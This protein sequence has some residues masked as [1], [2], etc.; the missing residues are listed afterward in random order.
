MAR[1]ISNFTSF[2][3]WRTDLKAKFRPDLFMIKYEPGD[4]RA[5]SADDV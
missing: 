5:D 4:P 1:L 2:S 3:R